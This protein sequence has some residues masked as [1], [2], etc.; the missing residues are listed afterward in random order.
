MPTKKFTRNK[1]FLLFSISLGVALFIIGAYFLLYERTILSFSRT[2]EVAVTTI[3]QKSKPVKVEI[4]DLNIDLPISESR[5]VNRIWEI[6]KN[7]ASHLNTSASP[8]EEGNIVIY[9]HNRK[10]VFGSLPYARVGTKIK[11]TTEDGKVHDYEVIKK[12]T[13]KPNNLMYVLP[14]SEEILTIYTC[15]GFL[16][17]MRAV[18][19]AKPL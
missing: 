5:I 10:V 16:D 13:V 7:G 3:G 2:P 12:D 4:G 8:G 17:S 19:V 14:A 11:L 1:P 9:G 18:L 15:T 6:S